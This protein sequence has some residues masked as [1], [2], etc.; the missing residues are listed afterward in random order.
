MLERMQQGWRTLG[1]PW[2]DQLAPGLA[3]AELERIFAPFDGPLPD[4]LRTFWGW[5]NGRADPTG[6]SPLSIGATWL[7][8]QQAADST[9]KVRADLLAT[10]E[11]PPTADELAELEHVGGPLNRICVFFTAGARLATDLSEPGPQAALRTYPNH[12]DRST[13]Q[14]IHPSLGSAITGLCERYESGAERYDP[15]TGA[16]DTDMPLTYYGV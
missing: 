6:T 13:G 4:E 9:L 11:D 7:T 14:L 2:A 10:F 16:W 15:A 8:A 5:H 3:D 12:P 1:I